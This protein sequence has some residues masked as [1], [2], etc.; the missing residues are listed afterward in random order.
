M[1]SE[2][3]TPPSSKPAGG[4]GDGGGVWRI[5]QAATVFLVLGFFLYSLRDL[6]SP[7]VLFW[8]LVAVLLPFRGTP[9]HTLFVVIA[10]LLTG[11][12]ILD[13]TG[14]LLAPFV[15]ALVLAYVFDP[16]VDRMQGRRFRRSVAIVVLILPVLGGLAAALV[17]GL[18]AL[19]EQVGELIRKAPSALRDLADWA[20]SMQERFAGAD[21]PFVDEEEALDRLRMLSSADLVSLL[22]ARWQEIVRRIWSGVLGV[23]RGLGSALTVA[24]YVILTP[25]LT[26]Y[27]I[28]DYDGIV[29]RLRNLI[30]RG[31]RE[32]VVSFASAYD[33]LLSRYLRGQITVALIVGTI[34]AL[35]LWIARFPYAFLIG[36]IVAVF[37]VVPYLGL[38]LSLIP[39]VIVALLSGDVL[40]SLLKVAVVYGIAQGLEGSLI[41]PKIVGDSVGLHPVWVVLA[42][43]VGGFFFGFVGL[44]IA[45]PV[46]VGVKLAVVRGLE[47]YESSELYGGA[48][49]GTG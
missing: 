4:P 31:K 40:A 21:L 48:S 25:V 30:P 49:A 7:F 14:F 10:A 45:V 35:G 18:P 28:R 9:G 47:R 24:G 3:S 20:E 46:A 43:A 13:T 32:A 6:L 5:A 17:L 2:G 36:A 38:L 42:L 11:F 41:S 27:L 15:L 37:S 44:L 23:G 34:T 8:V 26:F 1:S 16:L 33:D 29:E 12:W 39:A 19:G 22:E